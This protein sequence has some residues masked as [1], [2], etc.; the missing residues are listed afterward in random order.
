MRAVLQVLP[1]TWSQAYEGA[2]VFVHWPNG[3]TCGWRDVADE[4]V[5]CRSGPR[6]MPCD[7]TDVH[8]SGMIEFLDTHQ[9]ASPCQQH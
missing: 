1:A 2:S 8:R 3:S 5:L 9:A 7:Q 6:R 4:P